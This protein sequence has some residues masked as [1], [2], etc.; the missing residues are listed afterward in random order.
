MK[1]AASLVLTSDP[2]EAA[3]QATEQALASLAGQPT[4]AVLFAS[5]HFHISAPALLKAVT[6]QLGPVPLIGCIAEA[7]A[8]NAREVENEPAVSLFLAADTGPVETF[9]MQFVRTASGGAVGG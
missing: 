6:D 1:A 4:F 8:G 5:E 7:V 9:S 3:R 2:A